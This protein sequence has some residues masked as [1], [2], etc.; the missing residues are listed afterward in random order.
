MQTTCH[1]HFHPDWIMNLSGTNPVQLSNADTDEPP[2][3]T[4][5]PAVEGGSHRDLNKV[6]KPF[7]VR[8]PLPKDSTTA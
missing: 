4:L 6:R 2:G 7:K 1:V 8:E 5:H 3:H